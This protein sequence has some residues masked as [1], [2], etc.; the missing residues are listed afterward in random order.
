MAE[1]IGVVSGAIT[2]A[3]TAGKL[4]QLIK[5]L[6][7]APDELLALSNEVN[8][9]SLLVTQLRNRGT[10]HPDM[11][12]H[13]EMKLRDADSKIAAIKTFLQKVDL[14]DGNAL[15]RLVWVHY[16]S[17]IRSCQAELREIRLQA[18]ALMATSNS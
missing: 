2:L 11:R 3:E 15:D 8:D 4:G 12:P 5:R 1:V 7:D 13:L 18:I 9:F 17:K 16:R 6:R 14:I 10:V